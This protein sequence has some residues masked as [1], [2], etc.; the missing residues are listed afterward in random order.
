[1]SRYQLCTFVLRFFSASTARSLKLM[2]ES[3]GGQLSPFCEQL[4]AASISHSSSFTGT[5]PSDVTQSVTRSVPN[6]WHSLPSCDTSCHAPVDVSAFTMPST[7][8]R[9][10]LSV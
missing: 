7:F 5:H 8:G 3:P 6:S 2:G 1:M 9:V 10:C 4:N